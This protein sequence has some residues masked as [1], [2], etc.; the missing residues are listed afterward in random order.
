MDPKNAIIMLDT[1]CDELVKLDPK[2][3]DYYEKNANEYKLQMNKLDKEIEEALRENNID[4]LV[5][6]GEFAYAYF[7]K[8]YD[9][10]VLSCYTACGEGAEP[11]ISR[12]KDVIDY[13]NN[14]NIPKVFYEELSEGTV[15]NMISE[16]T[17]SK[18]E[19]FNTLHNVSKK[20]ILIA[21]TQLFSSAENHKT[22]FS[23]LKQA[24]TVFTKAHSCPLFFLPKSFHHSKVTP[25][26]VSS[27]PRIL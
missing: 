22:Q 26:P 8:R 10:K 13:I 21:E 20:E 9:L 3:K 5:V 6:G 16:E 27:H 1:I 15:A 17:N 14:N 18:A 23:I 12:I 7:C 25:Y 4:T 19:V 2:N 24:V 11:S